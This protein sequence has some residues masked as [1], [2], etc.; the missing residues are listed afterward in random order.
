MSGLLPGTSWFRVEHAGS[1]PHDPTPQY[2]SLYVSP[3]SAFLEDP[4][5][6]LL[7]LPP[8]RAVFSGA[9]FMECSGG[10]GQALH[11]PIDREPIRTKKT[12][13][14]TSFPRKQK[15][16]P[17]NQTTAGSPVSLRDCEYC[18]PAQIQ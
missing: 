7:F 18:P 4:S 2:A 3:R 9:W 14:P 11:T 13:N 8:L 1:T 17:S 6:E 12:N 5:E 15:N 16:R 10:A